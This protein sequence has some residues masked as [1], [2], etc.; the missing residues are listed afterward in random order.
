VVIQFGVS[1]H[2]RFI[3]EVWYDP[4]CKRRAMAAHA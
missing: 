3:R 2:E 4:A 1:R